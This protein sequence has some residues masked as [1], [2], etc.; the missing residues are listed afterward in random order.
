[1]HSEIFRRYSI[2]AILS[3][4]LL[5]GLIIFS[6]QTNYFFKNFVFIVIIYTVALIYFTG[7]YK[8]RSLSRY[9]GIL[10][11][12]DAWF[13]ADLSYN[14]FSIV[15]SQVPRVSIEECFYQAGYFLVYIMA[16]FL[17][18]ENILYLEKA[19]KFF[20]IVSFVFVCRIIY[21]VFFK[22]QL[23]GTDGRISHDSM[24][25][26]LLASFI[27]IS[28]SCYI[29]FLI[30]N[31][32]EGAAKTRIALLSIPITIYLYTIFLTSSRGGMLGVT[33]AALVVSFI[34]M[35]NSGDLNKFKY[36]VLFL[37]S[38]GLVVAA[39]NYNRVYRIFWETGLSALRQRGEIWYD[40][41][42]LFLE[43]PI[44]GVGASVCCYSIQ[45]FSGSAMVDA[46]NFMLQKLC[47]FGII[48]TLIY[49]MPLLLVFR[50]ALAA[51]A[52]S[53]RPGCAYVPAMGYSVVFVLVS[54]FVNSSLSPH[55]IL[56]S[57]SLYLY[58]ILGLFISA[59]QFRTRIERDE[60][61]NGRFLLEI[62]LV[63]LASTLVYLLFKVLSLALNSEV[64]FEI[65]VWQKPLAL[66]IGIFIYSFYLSNRFAEL[67][68]T[69]VESVCPDNGPVPILA[70]ARKF[71]AA[72]LVMIIL[73]LTYPAFNYFIAEKANNLAMM[74][75]SGYSMKKAGNYFDIA[76]RHDPT[77]VSYLINK[78]YL[79]FMSGFI[80]NRILKGNDDLKDA[81]E[82]MERS[83]LLCPYDELIKSAA[84]FLKSKYVGNSDYKTLKSDLKAKKLKGFNADVNEQMMIQSCFNAFS[85]FVD[86]FGDDGYSVFLKANEGLRKKILDIMYEEK[87]IRPGTRLTP[88]FEYISFA[89]KLG[90]NIDFP[91][92][93]KFLIAGV[94]STMKSVDVKS[95]FIPVSGFREHSADYIYQNEML[96]VVS[97]LLPVIWK[98][99]LGMNS[100]QVKEQFSRMFGSDALFPV[101]DYFLFNNDN[102]MKEFTRFDGVLKD[103]LESM[104][105]FSN[106]SFEVAVRSHEKAF[107]K[108]AGF[109]T[110]NSVLMSWLYYKAGDLAAARDITLYCQTHVLN[111]FKRDLTFKR[112]ILYGGNMHSFYYLPIQAYYNEYI[113]LA[114]IRL[115]GGDYSKVIYEV[116]KYLRT[117]IYVE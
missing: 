12:V 81:L 89:L 34:Y 32:L 3:V 101:V 69:V 10:N 108:N 7:I 76:I 45:K 115:N 46:H 17:L 48:G 67:R 24:H 52:S 90:V 4:M 100:S 102:A 35:K 103:Y 65:N 88:Y 43:N 39:L 27:L 93:D 95:K 106:G 94:Y 5:L 113:M 66:F 60:R 6:T 1:M 55:Y 70:M 23:I 64:Y 97:T 96:A 42:K 104:A 44:F 73:I 53:V 98:N 18:V 31:I 107:K 15:Y 105:Y 33:L 21:I 22:F 16:R 78:S 112:D 62:M 29:F 91:N 41:A 47:D 58:A 49:L 56:P 20:C 57:L 87:D 59:E 71:S 72:S 82:L 79:L 14:V 109:S 75:V 114:L 116:F 19:L 13:L 38:S 99:S 25:P 84:I 77:N 9:L 80:K 26:N 28:L 86:V 110:L 37:S 8:S 111:N 61:E 85:K 54:V 30:K 51:A 92:I 83:A 36:V 50:R 40:A 117:V 11:V 2:F 63:A 74:S 68:R